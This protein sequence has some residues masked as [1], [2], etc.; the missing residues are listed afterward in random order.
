[1]CGQDILCVISKVPFEIPHKISYPYTERC[2]SIKQSKLKSSQILKL[3]HF[4]FN[5]PQA[6]MSYY[7]IIAVVNTESHVYNMVSCSKNDNKH[8]IAG[9]WGASYQRQAMDI[10]WEFKVWFYLVH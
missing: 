4:F 8:P 5:V 10:I 9:P 2:V 7:S 1:M 3:W 6:L